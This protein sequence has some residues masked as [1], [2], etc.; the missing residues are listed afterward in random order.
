M[1]ASL[2]SLNTDFTT[3]FGLLLRQHCSL[4]LRFTAVLFFTSLFLHFILVSVNVQGAEHLDAT[5]GTPLPSGLEEL[6]CKIRV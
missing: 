3:D 5:W 6:A 2:M 1:T 4:N